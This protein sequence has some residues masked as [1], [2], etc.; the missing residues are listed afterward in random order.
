M[1]RFLL[2]LSILFVSGI[3]WAGPFADIA[4]QPTQPIVID[5]PVTVGTLSISKA[6]FSFMPKVTNHSSDVIVISSISCSAKN[7]SGKLTGALWNLAAPW[8]ISPGITSIYSDYLYMGGLPG[9][10]QVQTYNNHV[11]C[12]AFGTTKEPNGADVSFQES[13]TFDV[14]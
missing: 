7:S 14:E 8:M 6:W 9:K 1:I 4:I 5:G 12:F 2:S 10:P 13:F 11:T 3:S